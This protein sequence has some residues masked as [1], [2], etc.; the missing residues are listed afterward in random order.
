M[1]YSEYDVIER[2]FGPSAMVIGRNAQWGFK[3]QREEEKLVLYFGN[4]EDA[5]LA[6]L[7]V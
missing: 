3:R 1:E 7:I 5:L 6:R 2:R 4:E